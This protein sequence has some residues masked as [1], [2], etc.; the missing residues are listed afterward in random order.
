MY[1]YTAIDYIT[2]TDSEFHQPE[3]I[4]IFTPFTLNSKIVEQTTGAFSQCA[5]SGTF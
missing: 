4:Y 1:I 3:L 2:Y 5:I